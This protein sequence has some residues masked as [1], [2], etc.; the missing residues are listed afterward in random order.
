MRLTSKDSE[1][2][3]LINRFLEQG[4]F[5]LKGVDVTKFIECRMW[6][7]EYMGR[8]SKPPVVEKIKKEIAKPLR[9]KKVK[10]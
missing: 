2:L 7:K 8:D 5:T 6:I 3:M 9:K 4:T 10:K 1:Y